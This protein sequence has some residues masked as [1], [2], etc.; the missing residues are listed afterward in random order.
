[1]ISRKGGKPE[2][3]PEGGSF[4]VKRR[5]YSDPYIVKVGVVGRDSSGNLGVVL[6]LYKS[7]TTPA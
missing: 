1:L 3:I 4:E 5:A 2:K 6:Y 7:G